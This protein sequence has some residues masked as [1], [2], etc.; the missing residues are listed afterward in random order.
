MDQKSGLTEEQYEEIRTLLLTRRE[1]ILA[2]LRR[3]L[4]RYLHEEPDEGTDVDMEEG[5]ESVVDPGKEMDFD[6]LSRRSTELKLIQEAI[7]RLQRGEY[8]ICDECGGRIRF[9]RL[10]AMPF[11]LLCRDCQQESEEKA[12]CQGLSRPYRFQ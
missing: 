8:G 10:K 11:A 9:E 7:H 5:D 1:K 2:D 4:G 12:R 6:V 3:N